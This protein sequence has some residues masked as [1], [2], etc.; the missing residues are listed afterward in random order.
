MINASALTVHIHE[1]KYCQIIGRII[2]QIYKP[3]ISIVWQSV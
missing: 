1:K 3:K 2:K